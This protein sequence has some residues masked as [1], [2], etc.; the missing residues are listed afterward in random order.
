MWRHF[1]SDAGT[2]GIL[3]D[4]SPEFNTGER[5]AM[6]ADEEMRRFGSSLHELGPQFFLIRFDGSNGRLAQ[7]HHAGLAAFTDAPAEP[8]VQIEI[9]RFQ[10]RHFRS[11]GTTG[12]KRFQNRPITQ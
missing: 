3:A 7:W 11:T 10:S 1:A 8:L 4:D 6:P 9:I 2:S 5:F 12:I